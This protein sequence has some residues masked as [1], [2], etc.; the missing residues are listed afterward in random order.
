MRFPLLLLFILPAACA[1]SS[2]SLGLPVPLIDQ[3]YEATSSGDFF[4]TGTGDAAQSGFL[5]R[6]EG[7]TGV[8]F[9]T[10]FS[11]LLELTPWAEVN[12]TSA[13]GTK[14]TL[15]GTKLSAGGRAYLD[16]GF[17]H[18]YNPPSGFLGHHEY[19]ARQDGLFMDALLNLY[20]GYEFTEYDGEA[21]D[22]V[23][24]YDSGLSLSTGLGWKLRMGHI[25]V[26]PLFLDVRALYEFT[27]VPIEY[28]TS[29]S[30][31]PDDLSLSGFSISASVG[32]VF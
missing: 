26:P 15:K 29:G 6:F 23:G 16:S 14:G 3:E 12:G 5:G 11:L 13:G 28:A 10:P 18:L 31:T 7:P 30:A 32:Y 22:Q 2:V 17:A 21:V 19:P 27:L 8:P 9:H 20:T 25:H 24:D 4:P 1:G